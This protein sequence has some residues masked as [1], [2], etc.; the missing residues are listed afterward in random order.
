MTDHLT[1]LREAVRASGLSRSRYAREVL[2]R[3]PRTLRR[4]LAGSSPIPASVIAH[5][6]RSSVTRYA[7]QRQ[8]RPEAK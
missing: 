1:Q 5:L 7:K 2:V 4:W 8:A 6:S 3:D